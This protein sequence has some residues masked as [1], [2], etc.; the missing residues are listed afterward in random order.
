MG[1]LTDM[2]WER[3]RSGNIA[4]SIDLL[5]NH[6]EALE[7]AFKLHKICT[8]PKQVDQVIQTPDWAMVI[9]QPRAY[10]NY[11]C[12]RCEDYGTV[13]C[14]ADRWVCRHDDEDASDYCGWAYWPTVKIPAGWVYCN[15]ECWYCTAAVDNTNGCC[16]ANAVVSVDAADHNHRMEVGRYGTKVAAARCLKH[17]NVPIGC[18][19]DRIGFDMILTADEREAVARWVGWHATNGSGGCVLDNDLAPIL[20]II[21]ERSGVKL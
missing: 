6:V 18:A 13:I 16:A 12:P 20:K 21:L 4:M 1:K 17:I 2:A 19:A 14:K 5:S 7:E 11:K 9:G 15:P 3:I 10:N 8:A